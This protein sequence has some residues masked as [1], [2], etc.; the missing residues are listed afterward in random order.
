MKEPDGIR[1]VYRDVLKIPGIHKNTKADHAS[2][3]KQREIR[4]KQDGNEKEDNSRKE[5]RHWTRSNS[6]NTE[7]S[8]IS[9][10]RLRTTMQTPNP[11]RHQ[12]PSSLLRRIPF[13]IHALRINHQ[14]EN[15]DEK[16]YKIQ[17]RQ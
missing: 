2:R 8:Q 9:N 16:R 11:T 6:P 4:G 17:T 5:E 1:Y 12:L 3:T 14:R 10:C 13:I 15:G 7:S